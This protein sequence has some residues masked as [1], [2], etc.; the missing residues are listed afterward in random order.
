MDSR[1]LVFLKMKASLAN[2]RGAFCFLPYCMHAIV[3]TSQRLVPF[4]NSHYLPSVW[5]PY[6]IYNT[7][8]FRVLTKL[9][10]TTITARQNTL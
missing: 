3:P 10:Q 7:S 5:C 1:E 9:T 4:R 8:Q 2:G 6:E